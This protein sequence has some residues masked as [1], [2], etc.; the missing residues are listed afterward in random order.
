MGFSFIFDMQG[1]NFSHVAQFTPGFARRSLGML[2]VGVVLA[3]FYT[4]H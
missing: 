2:E 4:P 3:H 1:L